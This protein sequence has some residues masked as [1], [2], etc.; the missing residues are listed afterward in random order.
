MESKRKGQRNGW[1]NRGIEKER[2]AG[3][4]GGMESQREGMIITFPPTPTTTTTTSNSDERWGFAVPIDCGVSLYWG[5]GGGDGGGF[6]G[7]GGGG[8]I[9]DGNRDDGSEVTV[10]ICRL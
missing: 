6:G 2:V 3:M 1:K 10:V 5:F 8:D 7:D 4:E 9:C